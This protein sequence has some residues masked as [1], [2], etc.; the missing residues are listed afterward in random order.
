MK[1]S[2]L[3]ANEIELE[4]HRTKKELLAAVNRAIQHADASKAEHYANAFAALTGGKEPAREVP[5]SEEF[6]LR[7]DNYERDNLIALLH[8]IYNMTGGPPL[9]TG[10]WAGQLYWKLDP[11][12]Y[13]IKKHHPN[14]SPSS[15]LKAL[16]DWLKNQ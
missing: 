16:K 3:S 2:D 7:M 9:A 11:E 13:N 10:D 15:Q 8:L 12:G 1:K 5:S 4:V 14:I 6:V